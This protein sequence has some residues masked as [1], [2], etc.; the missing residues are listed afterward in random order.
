MKLVSFIR[1]GRPSFG[2]LVDDHT[3]VDAKSRAK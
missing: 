3:I 2:K 1:N